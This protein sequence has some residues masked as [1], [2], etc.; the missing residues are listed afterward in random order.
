MP[1][2]I[3]FL[4]R[5]GRTPVR[6]TTIL[7]AVLSAGLTVGGAILAVS[8]GTAQ[9]ATL[10]NNWYGAA[11]Y[12]MPLDNDPPDLGPVMDATGQKS[13]MLA[14][15]LAPNGGGC[16]PTWDGTAPLSDSTVASVIS[17]VRAK[18]GDVSVSI[19]GFGGTK[20]GQ[21]CG[22]P[23][24]T[25]A[26]YQQGINQYQLKAIDFDLGGPEDEKPTAIKKEPG[27]AQNL[28]PDNPR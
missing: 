7:G 26:A 27:A 23:P 12:V 20:L 21:T 13:F 5:I 22:S 11:P 18:G 14:F 3:K 19:G 6:R 17:K 25:P 8:G 15:V 4:Y 16:T 9:A 2:P 10:P 1:V 28:P 24:A